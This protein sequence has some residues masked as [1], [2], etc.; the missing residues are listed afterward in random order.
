MEGKHP[1]IKSQSHRQVNKGV[2]EI[3]FQY[4]SFKG[5]PRNCLSCQTYVHIDEIRSEGLIRSESLKRDVL[6]GIEKAF[7]C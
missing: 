5:T 2:L 1:G 3:T 7:Q 6:E 4:P